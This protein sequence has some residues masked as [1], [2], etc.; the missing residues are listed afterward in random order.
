[1]RRRREAQTGFCGTP[2]KALEK[3]ALIAMAASEENVMN[4]SGTA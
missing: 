1:M 3:Q 2:V 4:S